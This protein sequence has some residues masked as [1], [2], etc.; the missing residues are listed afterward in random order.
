MEATA[1][2]ASG[3][4][5]LNLQPNP[6]HACVGENQERKKKKT[7]NFF[8]VKFYTLMSHVI[9]KQKKRN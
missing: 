3:Q 5:A 6:T 1:F 2:P 9:Q 8:I 7:F 4:L